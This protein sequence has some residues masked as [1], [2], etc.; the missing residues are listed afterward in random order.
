MKKRLLILII[1]ILIAIFA[2]WGL[3]Q[4][5]WSPTLAYLAYAILAV[6]FFGVLVSNQQYEEDYFSKAERVVSAFLF[7]Y[8]VFFQSLYA[9]LNRFFFGTLVTKQSFFSSLLSLIL[10]GIFFFLFGTTALVLN[11]Y[12]EVGFLSGWR[13]FNNEK[14]FFVFRILFV[15]AATISLLLI[16]KKYF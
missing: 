9:P 8:L 5:S 14:M 16:A 13:I 4:I 3:T 10:F 11:K 15:P 12:S 2:V 1:S 6:V 7:S